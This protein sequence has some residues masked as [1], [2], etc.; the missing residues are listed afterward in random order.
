MRKGSSSALHPL[1][2]SFSPCLKIS[3]GYVTHTLFCLICFFSLSCIL[4]L[5]SLIHPPLLSSGYISHTFP[6][7]FSPNVLPP[8]H[9]PTVTRCPPS[10]FLSTFCPVEVLFLLLLFPLRDLLR[11]YFP[12][13]LTLSRPL[14]LLLLLLFWNPSPLS[15]A[16]AAAAADVLYLGSTLLPHFL[17]APSLL[18]LSVLVPGLVKQCPHSHDI[19]CREPPI[20][21]T[22]FC[23]WKRK[24]I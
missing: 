5:S 16:A 1:S 22:V 20:E 9:L 10:F 23:V 12:F 17:T 3:L 24:Y 4:F 21:V 6:L 7:C 13:L 18:P 8:F 19:I 15:A 11:A 14:L 2:I